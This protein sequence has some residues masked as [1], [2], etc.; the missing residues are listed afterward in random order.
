MLAILII[1]III[2]VIVLLL[3][4]LTTSKSYSY[5]HTVDT[6]DDNPHLKTEKNEKK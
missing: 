5:K 2:V 4:V 1:C 6:L 3:A